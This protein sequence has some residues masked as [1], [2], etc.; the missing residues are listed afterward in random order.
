MLP[1]RSI[2][3]HPSP[4]LTDW[5]VVGYVNRLSNKLRKCLNYRTPA[6]GF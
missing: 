1:P 5:A 2:K 6:E 4:L 3:D